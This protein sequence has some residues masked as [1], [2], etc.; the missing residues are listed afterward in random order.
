M[1]VRN[2]FQ[3]YECKE[4]NSITNDVKKL[5]GQYYDDVLQYIGL[6]NVHPNISQQ[7]RNYRVIKYVT[8]KNTGTQV[9]KL[10]LLKDG[11]IQEASCTVVRKNHSPARKIKKSKPPQMLR[12]TSF[13]DRFFEQTTSELR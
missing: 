6:G 9:L 8:H 1:H 12:K 11:T 2:N 13:F 5:P 7:Y 3:Q 4:F 10:I